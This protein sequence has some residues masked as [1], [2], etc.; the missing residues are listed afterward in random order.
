[1]EPKLFRWI[2][3]QH[4]RFKLPD[5]DTYSENDWPTTIIRQRNP[6]TRV[7]AWRYKKCIKLIHYITFEFSKS[8]HPSTIRCSYNVE[9]YKWILNT[10]A[11][12]K[13]PS[14]LIRSDVFQTLL[15]IPIGKHGE[16][17]DKFSL[18]A[19]SIFYIHWWK[20][21]LCEAHL[22]HKIY[23]TVKYLCL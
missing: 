19:R 5:R 10:V 1:M 7:H 23:E 9:K 4:S 17:F 14:T 16:P 15:I 3:R 20:H 13:C 11:D 2:H 22:F 12:S 21:Q 18:A 8:S 6:K